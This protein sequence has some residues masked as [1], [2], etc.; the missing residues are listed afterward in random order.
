MKCEICKNKIEEIFLSKIKGTIIKKPGSSKP[1]YL[2]PDCQKKHP[3][4]EELLE[5]I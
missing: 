1:H 5:K 2:C 3:K 4:K